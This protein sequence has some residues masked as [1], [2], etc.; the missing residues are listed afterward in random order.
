MGP[1]QKRRSDPVPDLRRQR[2]KMPVCAVTSISPDGGAS[3]LR[4]RLPVEFRRSSTPAMINRKYFPAV[5]RLPGFRFHRAGWLALAFWTGPLLAAPE[6]TKEATHWR[7]ERLDPTSAEFDETILQQMAHRTGCGQFLVKVSTL[8]LFGPASEIDWRTVSF[9]SS[10]DEMRS[11]KPRYRFL[12]GG[13]QAC[14]PLDTDSTEE[15]LFRIDRMPVRP[16]V[17]A[18]PVPST[19]EEW[20]VEPDAVWTPTKRYQLKL[21]LAVLRNDPRQKFQ[22]GLS[23][24]DNPNSGAQAEGWKLVREAAAQGYPDAI[25]YLQMPSMGKRRVQADRE[26]QRIEHWDCARLAPNAGW[27]HSCVSWKIRNVATC[28][29]LPIFISIRGTPMRFLPR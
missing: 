27:I 15:V 12:V 2:Y 18:P 24:L 9:Y 13:A 3:R 7:I 22:V 11:G 14:F 23:L 5:T 4:W 17:F 21:A 6:A 28:A 26:R 10:V 8:T 1:G 20:T 16:F 25:S 19:I 29:L